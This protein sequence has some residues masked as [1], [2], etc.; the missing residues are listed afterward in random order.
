MCVCLG[1]DAGPLPISLWIPSAPQLGSSLSTSLSR[2]E[3]VFSVVP[4][5]RAQAVREPVQT[6]ALYSLGLESSLHAWCSEPPAL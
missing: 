5:D 1:G 2:R 3:F 4:F 6:K